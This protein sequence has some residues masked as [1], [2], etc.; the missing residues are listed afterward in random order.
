MENSIEFLNDLCRK[1]DIEKI[2]EYFEIYG[3]NAVYNEYPIY[4]ASL[5]NYLDVLIKLFELEE[6]CGEVKYGEDAIDLASYYDRI[7]ILIKL[8]ELEEKHGEVKYSKNA[9]DWASEYGHTNTIIKLFELEEKYGEVKYSEYAINWASY[10]D[11]DTVDLLIKLTFWR[12]GG[13]IKTSL[14]SKEDIFRKTINLVR[15]G[16]IQEF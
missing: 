15:I 10:N 1:G 9:I 3:E 11:S 12:F 6:K 5:N 7:N 13:Y 16:K 14:K 2:K 8:F 4:W